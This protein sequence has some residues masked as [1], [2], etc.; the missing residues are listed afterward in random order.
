[1]QV[2]IPINGDTAL[3]Y[4]GFTYPKPLIEINGKTIIEQTINYY[5]KIK[6]V[7][8]YFLIKKEDEDKFKFSQTLKQACAGI[9]CTIKIIKRATSGAVA[10]CLLVSDLVDFTKETIIANYDQKLHKDVNIFISDYRERGADFGVITFDSVH[11]KW[12]YVQI[13]D[14]Q[15]VR[16]AEKNAISRNA[17][18]GFYYFSKF[19]H[20]YLAA[21]EHMRSHPINNT[22][23]FISETLNQLVINLLYGVA[24]EIERDEYLN[25]YDANQIKNAQSKSQDA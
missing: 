14:G 17:I 8:I 13:K 20:F 6:N 2:I 4:D 15:I 10:T 12:S 7:H 21:T 22:N 25:Y 23:Y 24:F 5:A 11:P 18:T 9:K 3:N 19:E 1:M 16:A